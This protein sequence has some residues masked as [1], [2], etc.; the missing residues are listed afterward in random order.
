[1][2]SGGIEVNEFTH[3]RLILEVKFGDEPKLILR[4]C[5]MKI[6][7]DL[8]FLRDLFKTPLNIFD[9]TSCEIVDG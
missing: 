8:I 6:F 7:Y 3:I 2:I 5:K 4:Q 9:G 1:M